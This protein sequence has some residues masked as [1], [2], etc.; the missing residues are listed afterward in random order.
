MGGLALLV[1][2]GVGGGAWLLPHVNLESQLGG[3]VTYIDDE[4]MRYDI[5][6]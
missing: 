2:G 5:D 6:R 4:M 3:T 1:E